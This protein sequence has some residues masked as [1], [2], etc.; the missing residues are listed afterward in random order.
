MSRRLQLLRLRQPNAL[1]S[2]RQN[3]LSHPIPLCL[4]LQKRSIT[5]DEKPL[6]KADKPGP[7]PNQDQ[8]PHVSEEAAATGKITGD[9]GPEIEQ[10]TPV[11]EVGYQPFSQ[12]HHTLMFSVQILQRDPSGQEKAPKIIQEEL[13]TTAPKGSRQY[14]T[15]ARVRNENL[16]LERLRGPEENNDVEPSGHQFELPSLPLPRDALLKYRY[17][18]MIKQFTNLMMRDGKLS[19]AQRVRPSVSQIFDLQLSMMCCHCMFADIFCVA[20]HRS[21]PATPPNGVTSKN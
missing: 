10:G 15:S 20:E 16:I 11:Q 3:R 14:S 9:G 4:R 17:D 19:T 21:D 5:A 18:P 1:H 7:G 8:L 2:F 13:N 6:P 12:I